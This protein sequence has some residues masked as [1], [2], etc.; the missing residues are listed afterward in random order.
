MDE[1]LKKLIKPIFSLSIAKVE[2]NKNMDEEMDSPI[3]YKDEALKA[4]AEQMMEALSGYFPVKQLESEDSSKSEL[5]LQEKKIR[6][7]ADMKVRDSKLEMF[8]DGLCSFLENYDMPD[9][10]ENE[11][12]SSENIEAEKM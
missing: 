6:D 2:K 3:S 1:K 12:I 4:S 5:E 8:I 9:E 7:E 11:E 10:K